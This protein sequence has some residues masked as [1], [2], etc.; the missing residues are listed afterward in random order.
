VGKLFLP[1]K[2]RNKRTTT[3]LAGGTVE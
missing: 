1:N 3:T 2:K